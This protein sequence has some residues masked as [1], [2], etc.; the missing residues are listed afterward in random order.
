M[1]TYVYGVL[2][3]ADCSGGLPVPTV[4]AA[5]LAALVREVDPEGLRGRRAELEEH[6]DVLQ[7][8]MEHGTV[9]PMAFGVVME[10]E[11]SVRTDLL[12]ARAGELRATL[13][14]L[15]GKVEL[16]L[17][18]I[19]H[20]EVLLREV[21]AADPA[22]IAA[23]D[24]LQ[25]LPDAATHFE[26]IRLGERVAKGVAAVREADGAEIERL[27]APLCVARRINDLL[28]ER[29]A[30]NLALLIERSRLEELEAVLERHGRAQHGRMRLKLT[31]P[32]PVFSFLEEAPAWA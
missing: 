4:A 9:V 24:R 14:R 17:Q 20:E 16:S 7:R 27:V 28:H 29:M 19:Y 2:R 25:G 10:D 5:G 32:L 3:E 22:I 18:A 11:E 31:G 30:V 23:R 6:T 1:A 15:D 26:R 12:E 8:A 13:E 21:A